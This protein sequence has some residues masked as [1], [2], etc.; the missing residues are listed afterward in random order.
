MALHTLNIARFLKYVWSFF[1]IRYER[2]KKYITKHDNSEKV[3]QISKYYFEVWGKV[4]TEYGSYYKIECRKIINKSQKI[5]SRILFSL[6]LSKDKW[7]FSRKLRRSL[8][9]AKNNNSS[10]AKTQSL[11]HSRKLFEI[12]I[13]KIVQTYQGEAYEVIF[14][15]NKVPDST[16]QLYIKLN[17]IRQLFS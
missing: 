16:R 5:F 14:F 11:K 7:S 15:S 17:L 10:N 1:N 6:L 13:L 3:S 8:P 2:V 4:I 9:L 12:A